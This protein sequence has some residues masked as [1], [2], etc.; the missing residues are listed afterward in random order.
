M[1]KRAK[2][3]NKLQLGDIEEWKLSKDFHSIKRKQK[4]IHYLKIKRNEIFS[5][6]LTRVAKINIAESLE[7]IKRLGISRINP[8]TYDLDINLG[9]RPEI[10]EKIAS[11]IKLNSSLLTGLLFQRNKSSFRGTWGYVNKPVVGTRYCPYCLDEDKNEP[12]F[13]Y[14]WRM[15]FVTVCTKH[16]CFLLDRCPKCQSHVQ[17]WRTRFDQPIT[18]CYNCGENLAK[19][20]SYVKNLDYLPEFQ[21]D[22]I[23]AFNDGEWLG[24]DIEPDYFFRQLWKVAWAETANRKTWESETFTQSVEK[25]FDA[26]K[27]AVNEIRKD[28]LRLEKPF[29]CLK[30]SSKY[31]KITHLSI[32]IVTNHED[33]MCPLEGCKSRKIR[34]TG[35]KLYCRKCKTIFTRTYDIIQ[36][37]AIF[38]KCPLRDCNSR[39]FIVSGD[40]FRCRAC[41]T[42]INRNGEII[43]KGKKII[44][45]PLEDCDSSGFTPTEV[46]Y[47]CR[48]C[49]TIVNTEGKMIQKGTSKICPVDKCNSHNIRT[50]GEN[51]RCQACGTV[52]S[53][54]NVVLK[55]GKQWKDLCPLE[56]C[57]SGTFYPSG[58]DLRCFMCGTIFSVKGKILTEG[59]VWRDICPLKGCNSKNIRVSKNGFRCQRCNSEF[60][61]DGVISKKGKK[62]NKCL[63]D[64][65]DSK[66]IVA[67]GDEFRCQSCGSIFTYDGIIVKKGKLWNGICPLKDCS[68]KTF[69]YSEKGF[70]CRI[71]GTSFISEGR[72]LKKGKKIDICP[73]ETCTSSYIETLGDGYHCKACGSEFMSDGLI[74]KKRKPWKG[75]CPSR[76]CSSKNII[77]S[78]VGYQ[79][80]WCG[81]F[82][83]I[84]GVI[85]KKGIRKNRK[86][87]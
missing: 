55:N 7:I 26:L 18:E 65:C 61:V 73:S 85:T 84:D 81:S 49:G 67:S 30:C 29:N 51:F 48:K 15:K 53:G 14:Y 59:I 64:G 5:S 57:T 70:L 80:Q 24:K 21:V 31:S 66:S 42:I 78:S 56:G 32:H 12:Y 68:S 43:K 52:F 76:A 87:D 34:I 1:T 71:C 2:R 27:K 63:L 82:F 36:K 9:T 8:N 86:N 4:W 25:T 41:G 79:C 11:L 38:K 20:K 46:G 22:L 44:S 3:E 72:I 16:K 19:T 54:E 50:S 62:Y 10:I 47:R 45:C 39:S 37:G 33:I 58:E 40:N 74:T 17:Y 83:T 75:S 6:Y 60:N 23:T 69:R 77:V 13:R 35:D 28:F